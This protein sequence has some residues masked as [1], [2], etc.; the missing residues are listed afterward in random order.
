MIHVTNNYYAKS[1]SGGY[2]IVEKR[3]NENGKDTYKTLGY[4]GDIKSTIEHCIKHNNHN[5]IDGTD[6]ELSDALKIICKNR[7]ECNHCYGVLQANNPP[8]KRRTGTNIPAAMKRKFIFYVR[9]IT[10]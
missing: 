8:D 4:F 7:G 10:V 3:T 6:L 9:V 5:R 2:E 1:I